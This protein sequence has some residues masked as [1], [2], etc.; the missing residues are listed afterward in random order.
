MIDLFLERT[1]AAPFTVEVIASLTHEALPCFALHRVAWRGSLLSRDGCRLVCRFQAPDVESCRIALRQAK[2][3]A[4]RLWPGTVHEAPGETAEGPANANVLVERS[5]AQ[6]VELAR[7]QALEDAGVGCLSD[8]RVRFV[9]TFFSCD[10]RR[11][12]CLYRAGD[13]ESVRQAQRQIGMPMDR[14]W[15]FQTIL[16]PTT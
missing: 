2:A 5:F 11:M 14:V 12:L 16:P 3:D 15:A 13:A 9:R 1:F 7:I 8:Y 6:A 4:S 10:A